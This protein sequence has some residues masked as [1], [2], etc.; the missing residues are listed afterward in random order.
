[1]ISLSSSRVV[2]IEALIAGCQKGWMVEMKTAFF[3]ILK[4][5]I[6]NTEYFHDMDS[7]NGELT[8]RFEQKGFTVVSHTC[9]ETI[10]MMACNG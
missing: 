10:I 6:D 4:N 7:C 9:I 3:G 8:R 2:L 5:T 1:M